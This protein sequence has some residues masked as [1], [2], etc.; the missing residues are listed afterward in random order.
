[1]D[2]REPDATESEYEDCR[3]FL[4]FSCIEDG[5]YACLDRTSHNTGDFERDLFI[6]LYSPRGRSEDIF[7]ET[8]EADTSINELSVT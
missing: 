5:A 2:D 3:A 6:D 1:L 4:D 7:R 8:A